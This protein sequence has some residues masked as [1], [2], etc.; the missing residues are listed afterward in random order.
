M[1]FANTQGRRTRQRLLFR[2]KAR[3]QSSWLR[4]GGGKSVPRVLFYSLVCGYPVSP[5]SFVEK[6]AFSPLNCLSSLVEK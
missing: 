6:T 1:N 2:N 3:G 5:I 4:P